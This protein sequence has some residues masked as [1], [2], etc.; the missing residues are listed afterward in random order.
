M[1]GVIINGKVYKVIPDENELTCEQ[2]ALLCKCKNN[3]YIIC[4]LFDYSGYFVEVNA[5]IIEK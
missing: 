2:C 3:K 5:E 4:D 1:D